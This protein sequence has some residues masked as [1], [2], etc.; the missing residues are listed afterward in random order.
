MPSQQGRYF[1]FTAP[2]GT[3]DILETRLKTSFRNKVCGMYLLTRCPQGVQGWVYHYFKTTITEIKGFYT[4]GDEVEILSGESDIKNEYRDIHDSAPTPED[5]I[6]EGQCRYI[7][8][9]PSSL[10]QLPEVSFI[11]G[12]TGTGKTTECYRRVGGQ[13][14][15]YIKTA[16]S[17]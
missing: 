8:E 16:N 2:N 12:K 13:E 1:S 15:C 7:D 6:S 5:R 10:T 4:L 9:K 11:I 14:K 17:M 3:F